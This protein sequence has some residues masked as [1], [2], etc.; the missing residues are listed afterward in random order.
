[1]KEGILNSLR[2]CQAR[3]EDAKSQIGFTREILLNKATPLTTERYEALSQGLRQIIKKAQ[4]PNPHEEF[5]RRAV[6]GQKYEE[7]SPEDIEECITFYKSFRNKKDKLRRELEGINTN[8][9]DDGHF[10]L[11]DALAIAPQKITDQIF[12]NPKEYL[13]IEK[14]YKKEIK[15]LLDAELFNYM[16]LEEALDTYLICHATSTDPIEEKTTEVFPITLQ[17]LQN[18]EEGTTKIKITKSKKEQQIVTLPQSK[19]LEAL[20]RP[21]QAESQTIY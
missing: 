10:D 8:R 13:E 4:Y 15:D 12:R 11:I 1:M 21:V 7:N 17:I 14:T 3:I 2:K 9:G 20:T 19:F 18:S 6:T 5:F 16:Q